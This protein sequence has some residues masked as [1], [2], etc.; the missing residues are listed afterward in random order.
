MSND[1]MEYMTT[2]APVSVSVRAIK[3]PRMKS[4]FWRIYL[5]GRRTNRSFCQSTTRMPWVT[6][7]L[8]SSLLSPQSRYKPRNGSD[9]TGANVWRNT[10]GSSTEKI[11]WVECRFRSSL[12]TS[13][14]LGGPERYCKAT[15][16]TDSSLSS[17]D[18][19]TLMY[20]YPSL[21]H[22]LRASA[23]FQISNPAPCFE[24]KCLPPMMKVGSP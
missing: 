19:F 4:K 15:R 3:H 1:D 17:Y 9:R 18:G 24:I 23:T 16:A 6:S 5:P 2:S 12:R 22:S 21:L 11:G 10:P 13:M 20:A 14:V 7:V 8:F